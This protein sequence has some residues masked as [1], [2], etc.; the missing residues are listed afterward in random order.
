LV[1]AN[2]H[3]SDRTF[4][5]A[6]RVRPLLAT[7]LE[8]VTRYL[9][10]SE[11]IRERALA[12]GLPAERVVVTG[13]T[14]F[15]QDVP[16]LSELEAC[17]LRE[18]LGLG[19]EQPLFLAGST[20]E[21]EEEQVL[22]AWEAARQ[23]VPD[24]A[25]MIAPRHLQ[26]VEEI[27]ALVE[28][29]G[30]RVVRRS[31]LGVG[32]SGSGAVTPSPNAERPTPKTVLLLDT[33]GELARAYGLASV[34]FVGGSLVAKGGHDILQPLFHGVPTLYGPYMHNQRALAALVS[35]AGAGRVVA[36]AAELGDELVTLLTDEGER[37]ARTEA[38][39]RLLA[40]HQGA[41][42]RCA[43]EVAALV[44]VDCG[45]GSAIRQNL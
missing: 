43:A 44:S 2:G 16:R 34:A 29:R 32:R 12:V 38:G 42:A 39:A 28:A 30:L 13:H 41:A 40:A 7:I 18:N 27:S 14:K 3:I 15:D 36:D 23:H 4:R 19:R 11:L 37:A 26:R 17:S 9:A 21:G 8:G 20:H 10:Q 25:L 33:M 5:R 6:A 24:L 31:A 1:V 22:D 35:G 45:M